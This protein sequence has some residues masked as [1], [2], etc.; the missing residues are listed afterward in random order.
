MDSM[1]TLTKNYESVNLND[2]QVPP[3]NSA[4]EGY[5]VKSHEAG[6]KYILDRIAACDKMVLKASANRINSL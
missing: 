3:V 2:N 5:F 4:P 6:S 1:D